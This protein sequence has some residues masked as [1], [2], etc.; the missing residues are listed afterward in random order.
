MSWGVEV[1]SLLDLG[2][3]KVWGSEGGGVWGAWSGHGG[4]SGGMEEGVSPLWDDG[5]GSLLPSL[6]D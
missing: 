3:S 5:G 2:V 4:V 6:G 1:G